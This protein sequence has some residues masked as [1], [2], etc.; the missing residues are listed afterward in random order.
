MTQGFFFLVFVV[1]IAILLLQVA[2]LRRAS[3]GSRPPAR[4]GTRVAA[5]VSRIVPRGTAPRTRHSATPTPAAQWYIECQWTDPRSGSIYTFRSAEVDDATARAVHRRRAH[6]RPHDARHSRQLLRRGRRAIAAARC[7][8]RHSLFH[9]AALF[10]C[11][12]PV[13]SLVL[14]FCT[15]SFSANPQL[16]VSRSSGPRRTAPSN[17]AGTRLVP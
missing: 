5:V 17:R 7:P 16:P 12:R 15:A 11:K 8:T 14:L 3:P 13:N 6:R 4:P 1:I 2:A 10:P 9:S